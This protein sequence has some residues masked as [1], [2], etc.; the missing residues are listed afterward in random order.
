VALAGRSLA[1]LEEVQR[2][3]PA[4]ARAWP[5]LEVDSGREPDVQRLAAA[6]RVVCT[7]VGPYAK[8]GLPLMAACA[9]AGT[10][11][12]DL[13]GETL[14][15]RD[16]IDRFDGEARASGAR[17]VH[18][19]GFDSIPSDL[20]VLVLHRAL[21]PMRRATYVVESFRGAA[22]GGTFASMVDTLER[23][24]AEPARR[25]VLTDPYALSPDRAAEPA[26]KGERDLAT[27]RYDDFVG[28]WTA[29]FVM[30][31]VNTR[32]VRRS[33]A[34][35][36]HAYG[37]AFRYAEV[38]G[39]GQGAR[40]WARAVGMTAA[41]GAFFAAVATPLTRPLVVA[42]LPKPGEGPDEAKRLAGRVRIRIHG[43]AE[44][45]RRASVVV[46]GQGDPGYQLTSVM[47]GEAALCLALDEARLPAAAG[48]L[49]PAT[50]MGMVL[51]DRLVAAGM[52]FQVE[53]RL[54]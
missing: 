53:P 22:S 21:G 1:R 31:S 18:T 17:L 3:L 10:H 35:L 23:G 37:K 38:S 32:V 50:A 52:T 20:G 15:M 16:C 8:Y 33:S 14:F 30:A 42:R 54:G 44:D 29:P 7:T 4:A 51:V 49:T 40:G 5:L 19:C 39:T 28:G 45:G 34:L 26:L 43:E 48:V 36:G 46:A 11:S 13:T 12:C 24:L 47:L 41:L 27:V 25:R 2:G 6:T 9:A